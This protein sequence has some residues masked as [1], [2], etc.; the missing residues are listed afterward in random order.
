M[1][2]TRCPLSLR[3]VIVNPDTP[4]EGFSCR[5]GSGGMKLVRRHRW[6]TG[7]GFSFG[8]FPGGEALSRDWLGRLIIQI[9][10]TRWRPG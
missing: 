2:R 8:E 10:C 3:I 7:S 1:E 4:L 6:R 5:L 9:S